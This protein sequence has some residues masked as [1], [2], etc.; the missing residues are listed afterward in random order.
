MLAK[1]AAQATSSKAKRPTASQAKGLRSGLRGQQRG[2]G[3]DGA[4]REGEAPPGQ[5]ERQALA[6]RPQGDRARRSPARRAR[7]P[8]PA[9]RRRRRAPRSPAPSGARSSSP[10]CGPSRPT[11][12]ID[13]PSG[14]ST[15]HSVGIIRGGPAVVEDQAEPEQ[16][17][18]RAARASRLSAE[19]RVA[20]EQHRLLQP[21]RRAGGRS[22]PRR[23]RRRPSAAPPAAAR[24]RRRRSGRGRRGGSSGSGPATAT[25]RPSAGAEPPEDRVDDDR[26]VGADQRRRDQQSRRR[27]PS[28]A[29]SARQP[30]NGAIAGLADVGAGALRV[31][32]PVRRPSPRRSPRRRT[33]ASAHRPIA[34]SFASG[35]V[36]RA[37]G[38]RRWRGCR[39]PSPRR[40]SSARC[41]GR[42][43]TDARARAGSFGRAAS[44]VRASRD[45]SLTV[46][47]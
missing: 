4:D 42:R 27:R 44:G 34:R 39:S 12:V 16:R 7:S 25:S 22:A 13:W 33:T 17:D 20:A 36:E 21:G 2:A 29:P 14:P 8:R 47:A 5:R 30:K 3:D 41:G 26:G 6:Q 28:A 37:G 32:D 40:T 18:R 19:H 35:P 43:G 1:A 46:P 11:A 31:P 23:S 15:I 45:R 9:P 24:W 38:R 10:A